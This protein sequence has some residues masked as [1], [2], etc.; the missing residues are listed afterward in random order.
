MVRAFGRSKV[1]VGSIFWIDE[2]N[3]GDKTFQEFIVIIRRFLT[4]LFKGML[5]SVYIT[6]WKLFVNQS[7]SNLN[8]RTNHSFLFSQEEGQA[9][10]DVM[11]H[12]TFSRENLNQCNA[13]PGWE[14]LNSG[15]VSKSLVSTMPCIAFNQFIVM[16]YGVHNNN[17]RFFKWE[18]YRKGINFIYLKRYHTC[19]YLENVWYALSKNEKIYKIILNLF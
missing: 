19:T 11:S 15:N 5:W 4:K 7:I 2:N 6:I 14:A 12:R 10:L 16:Y 3:V 1:S 17:V 18:I 8:P 13:S 9:H